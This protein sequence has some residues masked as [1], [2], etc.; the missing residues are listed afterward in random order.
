MCFHVCTCVYMTRYMAV[1][2]PALRWPTQKDLEFEDILGYTGRLSHKEQ[3]KFT[4]KQA[5]AAAALVV[6]SRWGCA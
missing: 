2:T 1:H 4:H 3:K 5:S 6:R